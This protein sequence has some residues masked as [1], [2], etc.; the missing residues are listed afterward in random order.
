MYTH[1]SM[2]DLTGVKFATPSHRLVAKRTLL[3]NPR[4]T[5]LHTLREQAEIINAIPAE[6]IESVTK[7]DVSKLG[8]LI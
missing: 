2:L 8:V 3:C 4:I 1:S 5:D 6:R 7:H